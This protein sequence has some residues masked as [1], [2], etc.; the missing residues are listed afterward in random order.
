MV[1]QVPKI[2]GHFARGTFVQNVISTVHGIP[3]TSF[4]TLAV[5]LTTIV[6]LLGIKRFLP[7]FPAPLMA[8]VA[9]IAGVYLLNLKDRGVELVGHIPQ[10]FP[11]VMTPDLSLISVLWPA[12]LGIALMSFTETV[13]DGQAFARKDEPT[14]RAN[15]ELLATPTVLF[16]VLSP[17]DLP[18]TSYS[19]VRRWER[20][21]HRGG[22]R[23]R[24][25]GWLG[26]HYQG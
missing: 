18:E 12:A 8:A 1:D 14:P 3:K 16:A 20:G 22:N 10:G 11:S 21:G 9:A 13:A 2:A 19:P 4:A 7:K 15:R 6:L 23:G 24:S 25:G 26:D 17:L 5:G